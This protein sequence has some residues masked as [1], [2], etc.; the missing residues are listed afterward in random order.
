MA[1]FSSKNVTDSSGAP[2]VHILEWHGS[3]NARLYIARCSRVV[4]HHLKLT[5]PVL[6]N[7]CIEFLQVT[8]AAVTCPSLLH[9]SWQCWLPKASKCS[10]LVLVLACLLYW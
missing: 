6:N 9:N 2:I 10:V 5:L 8:A 7:T 4:I 1:L 3:V